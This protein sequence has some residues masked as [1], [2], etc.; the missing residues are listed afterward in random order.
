MY[1]CSLRQ[2]FKRQKQRNLGGTNMKG[3]PHPM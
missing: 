1:V 2:L 3:I